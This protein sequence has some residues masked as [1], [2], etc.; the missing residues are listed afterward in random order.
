MRRVAAPVLATVTSVKFASRMNVVGS[1]ADAVTVTV[2]T[3]VATST[4]DAKNPA[5]VVG[6][7]AVDVPR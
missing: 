6:S 3:P 2:L 5:F 4:A 1:T 7:T